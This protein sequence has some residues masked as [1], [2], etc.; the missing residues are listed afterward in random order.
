MK[1]VILDC[2]KNMVTEKFGADKWQTIA[3]KSG[4]KQ[5]DRILASVDFDD[6]LAVSL[7]D[8]T[9]QTL[10]L[11]FE[12]VAYLFG[13]QWMNFY[14]SK[15]YAG[16]VSNVKSSKE[17]F[18]KLDSI[19]S[20]VTKNM[21]N[22]RPPKFTYEWINEKTLVMNYISKRNLIDLFVGLAK[23]VGKYYKE[24]ILVKKLSSTKVQIN[25]Y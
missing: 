11:T 16:Y 23:S 20:M 3:T 12:Q 22:S 17:L 6:K 8:S 24:T 2:L 9:C 13:E 1:G 19:H 14:V 25:F 4:A 10:N 21:E 5:A 15:I 7:I 18:L